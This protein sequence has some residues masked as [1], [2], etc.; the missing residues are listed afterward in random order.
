MRGLAFAALTSKSSLKAFFRQCGKVS[1]RYAS[2]CEAT[3][4]CHGYKEWDDDSKKPPKCF[5]GS[6]N[7]DDDS[8]ASIVFLAVDNIFNLLHSSAPS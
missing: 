5:L 6:N 3:K 2:S 8:S 1:F 4:C 7:W